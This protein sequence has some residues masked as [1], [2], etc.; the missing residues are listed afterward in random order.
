MRL[1]DCVL[2]V[3]LVVLVS[4]GAVRVVA[5]VARQSAVLQQEVP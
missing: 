2:V 3:L 4:V 5:V 1:G